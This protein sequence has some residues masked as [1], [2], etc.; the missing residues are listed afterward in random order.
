MGYCFSLNEPRTNIFD[1]TLARENYLR[2][3]GTIRFSVDRKYNV[4]V[5]DIQFDGWFEN[6]IRLWLKDTRQRDSFWLLERTPFRHQ[7]F[8]HVLRVVL[9]LF[10][11][12]VKMAENN[13]VPIASRTLYHPRERLPFQ[14]LKYSSQN[15]K[16][17]FNIVDSS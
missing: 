1:Q 3:E 13:L 7:V 2:P 16:L 9:T 10:F 5:V 6:S 12:V 11:S 15:Q 17:S 4:P 14:Q 8:P